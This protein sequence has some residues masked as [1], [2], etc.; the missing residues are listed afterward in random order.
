[1]LTDT[2]ANT[3]P[4]ACQRVSRSRSTMIARIDGGRRVQRDQDA[5]QRQHPFLDRHQHGDVG[6]GIEHAAATASLSGVLDGSAKLLLAAATA[7]TSDGRRGPR[8]EQRPQSALHRS[9]VQQ[10]EIQPERHPRADRQPGD[11]AGE[12]VGSNIFVVRRLA[13]DQ[14]HRNAWPDH[15]DRRRLARPFAERNTDRDGHRSVEHRGQR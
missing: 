12:S 4:I 1:M 7:N 2:A 15:A 14:Y 5:R 6:A 3:M 10:N 8:E 11:S 13:A 9:L